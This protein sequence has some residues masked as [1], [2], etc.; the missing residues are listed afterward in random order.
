MNYEDILKHNL[1][2]KKEFQ[3][4]CLHEELD[5][6]KIIYKRCKCCGKLKV[7]P[8]EEYVAKVGLSGRAPEY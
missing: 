6:I 4:E 2:V 7:V 5:D 3:G 1:K 8:D